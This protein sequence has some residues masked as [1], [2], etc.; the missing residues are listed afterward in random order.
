MAIFFLENLEP[1]EISCLFNSQFYCNNNFFFN[2]VWK[3]GS[4][5]HGSWLCHERW[6][7][8][9]HQQTRQTDWKRRPADLQTNSVGRELLPP[10]KSIIKDPLATT[11]WI[12]SLFIFFL[13]A[14]N[15][16]NHVFMPI[17][18]QVWFFKTF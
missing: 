6:T 5:H 4:Y 9:L 13:K 16:I 14:V 15:K 11:F 1:I 3:Q 2:S 10:S 17:C 8:W 12:I 7:V 18:F